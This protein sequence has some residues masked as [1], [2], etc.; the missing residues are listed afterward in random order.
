MTYEQVVAIA[1]ELPD[2]GEALMY[3]KPAVKRA[4]RFMLAPGREPGTIAVK[5]DWE[6][7]DRL[8]DERPDVFF[9]TPHYE[10]WPGFLAR[11]DPLDEELARELAAAAW[12]DAPKKAKIFKPSM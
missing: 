10:G 1:L 2:V 5:V 6:T 12:E 11:L 4:G 9:K 8:L 3:G 7:H